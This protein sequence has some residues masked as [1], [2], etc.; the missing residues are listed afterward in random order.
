MTKKNN[1]TNPFSED[2]KIDFKKA[3]SHIFS[4]YFIIDV[5][6]IFII[7]VYMFS[8]LTYFVS[9][10]YSL[11]FFLIIL[12]IF[13]YKNFDSN[14]K[15]CDIPRIFLSVFSIT[16]NLLTKFIL[17]IFFLLGLYNCINSL[18]CILIE[19]NN[20][21]LLIQATASFLTFTFLL[22]YCLCQ[23]GNLSN[24]FNSL[25]YRKMVNTMNIVFS[26]NILMFCN[27]YVYKSGNLSYLIY[28]IIVDIFIPIIVLNLLLKSEEWRKSF[29][30][31]FLDKIL[32]CIVIF[33]QMHLEWVMK[34]SLYGDYFGIFLFKN[35]F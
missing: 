7:L 28:F 31:F 17:T 27:F 25:S 8:K 11:L 15:I 29:Y 14:K 26:M 24:F 3:L 5:N 12:L 16:T 34:K 30:T 23:L 35:E 4:I 9:F 1:T 21:L 22:F 6:L 32:L 2:K 10:N 20:P 13:T 19:N 18:T 33:N